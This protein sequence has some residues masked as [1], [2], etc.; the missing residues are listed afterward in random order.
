MVKLHRVDTNAQDNFEI[1]NVREEF[2]KLDVLKRIDAGT[3]KDHTHI[4][5]EPEFIE[6]A[7]LDF[8]ELSAT[9]MLEQHNFIKKVADVWQV[10]N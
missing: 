7:D 2:A 1:R 4:L 5:W 9:A 10:L 3:I 8:V 6:E